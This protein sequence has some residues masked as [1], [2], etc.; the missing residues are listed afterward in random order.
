MENALN[1]FTSDVTVVHKSHDEELTDFKNLLL[2]FCATLRS[3]DYF[4][5][6]DSFVKNPQFEVLIG[7]LE[8]LTEFFNDKQNLSV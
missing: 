3:L 8:E 4:G 5:Q 6:D 2:N 7:S 1:A